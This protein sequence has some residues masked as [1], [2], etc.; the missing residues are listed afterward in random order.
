MI[1]VCSFFKVTK[2]GGKGKGR[3]EKRKREK[4]EEF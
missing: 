3:N 1:L 4:R 2:F